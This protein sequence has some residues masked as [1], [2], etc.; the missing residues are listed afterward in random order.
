MAS[1]GANYYKY[2]RIIYIIA[3]RD[4]QC[5]KSPEFPRGCH[6]SITE[7]SNNN[8]K[9]IAYIWYCKPLFALAIV[10]GWYLFLIL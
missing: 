6:H 5:I 4:Q 3:L 1:I 10:V 2:L 9:V 8:Y 7:L